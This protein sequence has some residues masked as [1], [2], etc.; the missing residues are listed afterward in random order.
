MQHV[1]TKFHS[2]CARILFTLVPPTQNT[3]VIMSSIIRRP[4][5]DN[6]SW[7]NINL[8]EI[9]TEN[10]VLTQLFEPVHVP[11]ADYVRTENVTK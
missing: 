3:W 6:R 9:V 1:N 10:D 7:A 8:S 4:Q 5:L 11:V 2:F